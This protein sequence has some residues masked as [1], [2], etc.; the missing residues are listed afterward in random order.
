MGIVKIVGVELLRGYSG[1]FSTS[2]SQFAVR[3]VTVEYTPETGSPAL[4]TVTALTM[5]HPGAYRYLPA[6]TTYAVRSEI[7]TP[8]GSNLLNSECD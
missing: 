5:L 1:H 8:Q 7:D 2:E 3:G 4:P 6:T